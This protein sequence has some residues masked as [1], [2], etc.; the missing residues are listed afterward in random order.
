M[1][2]DLF[3]LPGRLPKE[4]TAASPGGGEGELVKT[5]IPGPHP[6]KS[7]AA[8]PAYLTGPRW[9]PCNWSSNDTA[10]LQQRAAACFVWALLRNPVC[11]NIPPSIYRHGLYFFPF[12]VCLGW[13]PHIWEECG[14]PHLFSALYCLTFLRGCAATWTVPLRYVLCQPAYVNRKQGL[15]CGH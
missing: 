3:K 7:E 14:A 13:N 1:F 15:R 2:S 10:P 11:Q 4:H 6:Q 5:Q 8:G 12:K 9:C